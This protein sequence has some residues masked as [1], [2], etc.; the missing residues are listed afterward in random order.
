MSAKDEDAEID[1]DIADDVADSADETTGFA[2]VTGDA[3]GI[4]DAAD[5]ADVIIEVTSYREEEV[6]SESRITRAGRTILQDQSLSTYRKL[7]LRATMKIGDYTRE[8]SSYDPNANTASLNLFDT[9]ETAMAAS[10]DNWLKDNR[11]K[12]VSLRK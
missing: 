9:P 11:E 12:L 1:E 6:K 4:C 8:F 3:T 2:D 10:I 7:V 5:K